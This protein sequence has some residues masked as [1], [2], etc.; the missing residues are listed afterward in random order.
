M[1]LVM[2]A[3][4]NQYYVLRI[5]RHVRISDVV[6]RK[7]DFALVFGSEVSALDGDTWRLAIIPALAGYDYFF[8]RPFG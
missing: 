4:V 7:L 3:E 8:G 6:F 5:Q 2:T 1:Y